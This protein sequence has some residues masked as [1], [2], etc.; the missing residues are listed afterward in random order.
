MAKS[1]YK[2]DKRPDKVTVDWG[3][4]SKDFSTRLSEERNRREDLKSE[5]AEDTKKYLRTV[6]DTPQGQNQSAN[7]RMAS[8]AEAATKTRLMQEQ[9]LKSGELKLRDYYAQKANLE[10]GTTDLFEVAK[11]FNTNFEKNMQRANTNASQV[12]IWNNGRLQDFANPAKSQIIVDPETGEVL[13]AKVVDGVPSN[14]DIASVFSLKS[15]VNQEIDRV[16][17]KDWASKTLDTYKE[18]FQQ[19]FASGGSV[20]SKLENPKFKEAIDKDV[21]AKLKTGSYTAA[22]VLA[23]NTDKEYTFSTDEKDRG[24]DGVI[25]MI[26]N[27]QNPSSGVL[28]P[29]LTEAQEKEAS[30]VLKDSILGRLSR[31]ETPAPKVTATEINLADRNKQREVYI[32]YTTDL[33]SGTPQEFDTAANILISQFN[34][35]KKKGEDKISDIKRLSDGIEIT[36]ENQSTGEMRTVPIKAEGKGMEALVIEVANL[37]TPI[38][39]GTSI[40]EYSFDDVMFNPEASQVSK[41]VVESDDLADMYISVSGTAKPVVEMFEGLSSGK[42]FAALARRILAEKVRGKIVNVDNKGTWAGSNRKIVIDIDGVKT[43]IPYDSESY[44]NNM[45]N[46][47]AFLD[48]LEGVEVKP[49]AEGKKKLPGT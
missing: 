35:G 26:P 5:I 39:L 37:T 17:V 49:A 8:F 23:D 9:K 42:D 13:V 21:A 31:K 3:A 11:N 20:T 41:G 15:G 44:I 22:S 25:M 40:S 16:D 7:D 32:G 38:D 24:K 10:Q 43:E 34:R 6:Q 18:D 4:I 27:P 46:M 19:V 47:Q 45:T 12:E 36:Y 1:Y 29:D 33:V 2:F 48:K 28:I 30:K 14:T